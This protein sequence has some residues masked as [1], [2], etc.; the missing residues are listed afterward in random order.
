MQILLLLVLTVAL[1]F[2][3]AFSGQLI[4][5]QQIDRQ[6]ASISADI[7]RLQTENARL[8]AAVAES[9]GD[10]FVEREARER[11]GLIR[12]GDVPVVITNVPTPAP[13][14]PKPA[15]IPK[16][17]WQNWRDTFFPPSSLAARRLR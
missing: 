10:A 14:P 7:D 9:S 11:L 3:V 17:H 8:K 5:S 6:V 16:A 1:Y 15:P 2:G 13:A 12:S 4:T